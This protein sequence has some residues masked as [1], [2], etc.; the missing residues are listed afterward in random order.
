MIYPLVN[1][2]HIIEA[3][4]IEMILTN[5]VYINKKITIISIVEIHNKNLLNITKVK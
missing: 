3:Q 5:K 1:W 2:K 4:D